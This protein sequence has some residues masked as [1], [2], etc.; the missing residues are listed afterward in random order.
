MLSSVGPPS[1][2]LRQLRLHDRRHRRTRVSV[3]YIADTGT[4]IASRSC[5]SVDQSGGKHSATNRM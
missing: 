4:S 2:A 1:D 3:S 5:F